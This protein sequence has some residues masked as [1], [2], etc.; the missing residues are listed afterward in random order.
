MTK[1]E[2]SGKIVK[3]FACRIGDEKYPDAKNG[4]IVSLN[5][6]VG[7][8]CAG[9]VL[10]IDELAMEGSKRMSAVDF[11]NGRKVSKGDMFI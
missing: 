10:L 5:K 7:V 11:I 6:S 2:Q 9:G 1:H 4:E 3:I 8:A